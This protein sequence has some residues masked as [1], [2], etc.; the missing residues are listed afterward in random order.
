MIAL[1]HLWQH[2]R[3]AFVLF[4]AASLVA[5]FFLVRLALFSLYWA[6]P[7]H[8]NVT[9]QPWMTPGYL[10]YSWHV[11]PRVMGAAL[12][13]QPGARPTLQEIA[14]ARGV[15]VAQLL[16]EVEA[17]LATH[18]P[19]GQAPNNGPEDRTRE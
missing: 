2:H 16:E 3:V 17:L 11:D 4:C 8:R 18:A 15:P 7:A 10:A 14:E 12:Q 6:D 13:I 19:D 9:P 5:A 1:R